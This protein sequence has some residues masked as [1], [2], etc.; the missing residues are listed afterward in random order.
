[1]LKCISL[2]R[3]EARGCSKYPTAIVFRGNFRGVYSIHTAVRCSD[4]K[5]LQHKS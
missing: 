3:D 5:R 4:V 2:I 1:M